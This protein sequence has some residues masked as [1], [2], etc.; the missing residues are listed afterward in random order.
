MVRRS[1]LPNRPNPRRPSQQVKGVRWLFRPRGPGEP[2][3]QSQSRVRV[4]EIVDSADRP[5]QCLNIVSQHLRRWQEPQRQQQ[6]VEQAA[7]CGGGHGHEHAAHQSLRGCRS[8]RSRSPGRS[9]G[10]GRPRPA[11]RRASYPHQGGHGQDREG[12]GSFQRGGGD[13]HCPFPPWTCLFSTL[14]AG[15][16]NPPTH[17]SIVSVALAEGASRKEITN[18]DSVSHTPI[19]LGR[20]DST[21]G[22]SIFLPKQNIMFFAPITSESTTPPVKPVVC[23]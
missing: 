13:L 6:G 19:D 9:L 18:C 5:A 20:T 2:L 7:D 1:V 15:L 22:L 12:Y 14:R 8:A 23:A 4:G 16:A 21:S 10:T 11:V 3:R 17:C